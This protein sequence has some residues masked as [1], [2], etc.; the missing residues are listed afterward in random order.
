VKQARGLVWLALSGLATVPLVPG[1]ALAVG[2]PP[3]CAPAAAPVELTNPTVLGNGSP[4]SV[5]TVAI[6]TAL[7]AG[8]EITFDVGPAPT[9]IVLTQPLEVRRE[10]VLDG[11]GRVTLSGGGVHRVIRITNP[12]NAVYTLTLQHLGI[13]DGA[14][15]TESGAGVYKP[16]GGPWQAVSLTVVDC[17]LTDNV[18]V[19]VAVDQDDGGGAIY[20]V[21][22][23][24]VTLQGCTFEGNRGANGGAVYSLGS[25]VVTAVDSRFHDNRA[26]GTGGNPS[27]RPPPRSSGTI[28]CCSRWETTAARPR[29]C[30]SARAARRWTPGSPPARS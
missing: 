26:T 6:Q 7:D 9:T 13:A 17:A 10:T 2:L 30:P 1:A 11:A 21:G 12:S 24:Q 14:T 8:G 27:S 19:A 25:R 3:D 5:T 4:G 23:D 22:M 20:A 15:P 28:R 29:R 16:T 18:A